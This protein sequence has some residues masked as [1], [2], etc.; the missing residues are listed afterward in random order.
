MGY[1]I[2]IHRY[3]VD[4]YRLMLIFFQG[5]AVVGFIVFETARQLLEYCICPRIAKKWHCHRRK[6]GKDYNI[7]LLDMMDEETFR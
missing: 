3:I 4:K 2:R 5:W 7:R 1:D 6:K